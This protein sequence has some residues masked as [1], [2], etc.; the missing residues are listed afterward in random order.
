[1][2]IHASLSTGAVFPPAV[3]YRTVFELLLSVKLIREKDTQ[4]RSDLYMDFAKVLKWDHAEKT[5]KAGLALDPVADLSMLKSDYN[6]VR[7]RFA[8]NP[9]YWWSSIIWNSPKDFASK[10]SIGIGRTC[11]YLDNAGISPGMNGGTF[12]ELYVRWY[13]TFSLLAHGTAL[14]T[15][16]MAVD[17]HRPMGWQLHPTNTRIA[18]LAVVACSEI[19]LE[20]EAGLAHPKAGWARMYLTTLSKEA[21]EAQNDLERSTVR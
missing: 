5:L 21:C 16:M 14:A 4:N 10:Q 15:N 3:L 12:T 11:A 20:C 1:M 2:G 13:S 19:I 9:T 7:G 6:A 17:G 8:N 18:P